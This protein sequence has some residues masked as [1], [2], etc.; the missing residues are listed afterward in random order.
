MGL[1][2]I[3]NMDF[4]YSPGKP[5]LFDRLS[6][7]FNESEITVVL[8][9]NGVGKTSLLKLV[10]GWLRP[11]TGEV[12][13]NGKAVNRYSGRE[14]GQLMSLVPQSEYIPFEY[15]I[16]EYTLLGRIPYMKTL[17]L[18]SQ[19]TIALVQEAIGR[20]GLDPE[21]PRPI[22]ILS[23]GERQLLLLARS[24][25]QQPV[26]L[27][28]DEPTAHL[29][30]ANKKRITHILEQLRGEGL[31]IIMTTH[32][33][34]VASSVADNVVLLGREGIIAHGKT[35]AVLTGELLSAT[36]NTDITTETLGKRKMVFWW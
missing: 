14:R 18:P 29:D 32:E 19:D 24:L 16:L 28:L 36:Y 7:D 13:V 26:L 12:I 21:D 34:D 20:V 3:R 27:L 23:G 30:L 22:T 31:T 15:S 35:N 6:L 25:S 8:G 1:V 4:S 5:R 2:S 11:E 9:P 33:P 10:L 17:E